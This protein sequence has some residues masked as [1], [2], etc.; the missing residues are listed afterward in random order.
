MKLCSAFSLRARSCGVRA[1]EVLVS[2]SRQLAAYQ[3][4]GV[5]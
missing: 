4:K 5:V 3:A 1:D 2:V